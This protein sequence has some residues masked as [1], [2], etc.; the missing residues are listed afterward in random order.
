MKKM[1]RYYWLVLV[2][3]V[4]VDEGIVR[5]YRNYDDPDTVKLLTS[6]RAV[7]DLLPGKRGSLVCEWYQ[8]NGTIFTAGRKPVIRVW[9][10]DEEICIQVLIVNDRKLLFV[11]NL[12]S[13]L[14]QSMKLEMYCL[15]VVSMEM[16]R[17]LIEE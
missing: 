7:D 2:I 3:F 13:R 6:W 17:S 4:D 8:L 9:D 1:L 14:F 15:L 5:L 16:F 10:A 11:L 12:L